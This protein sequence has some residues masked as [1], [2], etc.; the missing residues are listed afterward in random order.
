MGFSANAVYISTVTL[1]LKQ[2]LIAHAL[3]NC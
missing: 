1:I 3:N 2:A